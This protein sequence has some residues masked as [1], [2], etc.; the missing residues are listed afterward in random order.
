MLMAGL[1][2]LLVALFATAAIGMVGRR[3]SNDPCFGNEKRNELYERRG[4]GRSDTI[5]GRGGGDVLDA[6]EY[7]NDRD[8]L[9]GDT[10]I[11]WLSTVDHDSRD[12]VSGGGG[13]HDLC[14][15]N[16]KDRVGPGC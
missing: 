2:A 6:Q 1:T 15:V 10:G 7:V 9:Y 16:L 8:V 13:K 11:D 4:D 12:Y 14:D 5:H 3:C